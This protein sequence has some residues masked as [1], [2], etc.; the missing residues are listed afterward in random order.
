MLRQQRNAQLT[1]ATPMQA[2]SFVWAGQDCRAYTPA[3]LGLICGLIRV[4]SAASAVG[5]R[6]SAHAGP[7]PTERV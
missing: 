1:G 5:C 2:G 3:S 7:D 6:A 4:S